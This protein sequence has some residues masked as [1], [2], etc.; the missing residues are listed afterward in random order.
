MGDYDTQRLPIYQYLHQP[1]RRSYAIA[2]DFFQGAFGGSFLNHQWLDRGDGRRFPERRSTTA[3]PTTCTRSST[4]T[5]CRRNTPLYTSPSAA[6]RSTRPLT[7]SC[8]A[9]REPPAATPPG[10][11]CGDFAVNTIQPF[12]QPYAPGTADTA[13]CRRRPTPTIGDRLTAAGVDWAWYS[14]GWSNAE[15]RR[16]RARAGPTARAARPAPT[17]RRRPGPCT[18]T[19]RTS[20]S[21]STTS[22]STTSPTTRPGTA[23]RTAHLRDEAEF[24]Q[25]A[26]RPAACQLKP[27][28][29]VK[30]IGEENEH[31]GYASEPVGSSHLVDLLSRS[32]T[33]RDARRTRW[34]SSRTTSSAGSGITCRRRVTAARPDR[35][36][37]GARAPGSRR[38]DHRAVAAELVDRPHSARHDARSSRRSS[39]ASDSLRSR[40]GTPRSTTSPASFRRSRSWPTSSRPS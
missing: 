22:R 29:F 7:A 23:A 5:A 37:S 8:N 40:R 35:T 16:R 6:R 33:G 31:P 24:I 25:Q 15:R 27:V 19:A 13:G 18:R 32:W 34:S 17:P 4:P 14:G 2:D 20:S 10:V 21:S 39:T 11:A 28:S 1:A 36:T 38:S 9:A 26:Q 12:Y 30:P 3:A